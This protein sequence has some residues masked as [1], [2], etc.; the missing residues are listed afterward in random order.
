[1]SEEPLTNGKRAA[2]ALDAVSFYARS[3]SWEGSSESTFFFDF[4]RNALPGGDQNYDGFSNSQ[5][6]SLLE[7]ARSTAD[8][9]KRAQ[10]VAKAEELAANLLPWIPNVQ[11]TSVLMLSSS[12]TGAP[13]SFSYMFAPWADTLGGKA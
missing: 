8:P 10:L 6:T 9:A 2:L 3:S 11:P 1:M 13:A 7:G 12:L 4:E 5:L